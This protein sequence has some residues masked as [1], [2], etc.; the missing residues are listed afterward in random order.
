MPTGVYKRVKPISEETREKL[1]KANKGEKNP[2][3]GKHHTGKAKIN[4]SKARKGEKM[5]EETKNK[6]R[7][8][9]TERKKRLGYLNS[10]ETRKKICIVCKGRVVW[11]KGKKCPEFSGENHPNW[12]G[13][14]S[15]ELYGFDFTKELK[16]F[17]RE[18]D[19]FTCK[20]CNKNGFDCHHID[21]DK[22]NCNPDNLI[23]LCRSCHMKTNYKRKYWTNYF[24][25]NDKNILQFHKRI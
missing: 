5:S 24:N 25:N 23:T 11:N 18:R 15:F 1:R 22:K 13:G 17:I 21:Y 20:V 10:E 2:F 8:A 6:L 16:T 19:K 3:Y 9:R 4:I 14:K 7:E 12:Q